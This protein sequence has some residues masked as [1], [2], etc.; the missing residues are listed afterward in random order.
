MKFTQA[1][2]MAIKSILAKKGRSF[3][4][5]LGIII[6]IA[7]VMTI[8]SVV[9]GQNQKM[10]DYYAAMGT[11]RITCYGSLWNGE[12]MFDKVYNY[13][14]GIGDMVVGVTPE[15]QYGGTVRYGVKNSQSMEWQDQPRII[16]GS[17]QYSLC[18]NFQIARGRDLTELDVDEYNQ[19]CVLGA[20][21]AR[22]FFDYTDPVGETIT[23]D[24]LPFTVVGL[25]AEKDA[26]NSYSLDNV[27]ILPYSTSR[28]LNNYGDWSEFT[29]KVKDAASIP[30][31]MALVQD[32]MNGLTQDN[33]AGYGGCYSEQ[34]WQDQENEQTRMMSLVLGGIAGISLLVGGIGI[35]NI[36]LVTVTERT[37]EIGI[38]R[39]IGAERG[40]I[41]TQFLVEAAMICGI[42]GII[43][44]GLGFVATNVA[45]KLI[46]DGLSLLPSM[47][48]TLGSFGFSVVLGILFGMYPAIKASGLQPV[49]ALRAE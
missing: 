27:I 17:S 25:Y 8:V 36:M 47:P 31:V 38:R 16:L 44:I 9:S 45:G 35:M 19:V 33:M 29:I 2:K 43:G 7:S 12:S 34:Q 49:V 24:G 39:A 4:T 18:N 20:R 5:M 10:L 6:G 32:Y 26:D 28:F 42:G 21:A 37:R 1:V 23:I 15:I 30:K 41:V 46:L 13:C 3:L 11:N 40:S 48:I 14:Q 22:V